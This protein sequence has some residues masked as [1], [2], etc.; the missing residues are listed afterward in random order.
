MKEKTHAAEIFCRKTFLRNQSAKELA[1]KFYAGKEQL[2]DSWPSWC[3]FPMA[4]TYSILTLGAEIGAAAET[5]VNTAGV[6]ELSN[7]TAALIWD[8]YKTVYRYDSTL[9]EELSSQELSGK[10][11]VEIFFRLPCPCAFIEHPFDFSGEK[12]I[13][14]FAWMEYD[15]NSKISELRL[16]YLL[17]SGYSLSVPVILSGGTIDDSFAALSESG[18]KRAAQ[19]PPQLSIDGVPDF[20]PSIE[21]VAA[22]INLVL[23][24]CS[25]DSDIK[26]EKALGV[27]RSRN[28][29]GTYKRTA[30]WDVGVI[31]GSALRKT[32]TNHSRTEGAQQQR[33]SVSP[34]MRRAHWHTFWT[35]RRDGE[36]TAVLKWLP[37]TIVNATID[38]ELP[39]TIHPVRQ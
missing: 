26:D 38:G 4:A 8:K 35:G 22:S 7:L 17:N 33:H 5:L 28:T 16:L 24:L 3:D 29:D 25:E 10:L 6:L 20:F 32:Y 34:H 18:L 12:A 15:A 14:F 37:P 2:S 39:T 27:K 36:R 19:L 11:P 31:V 9:D 13:G 1:Q 30:V 23:Y 21:D